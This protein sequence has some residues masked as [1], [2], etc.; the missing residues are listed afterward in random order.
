VIDVYL[1][2]GLDGTGSLFSPF[3][4]AAPVWANTIVV[5]Y[6]N[7]AL[8]DYEQL[9][10]DVSRIIDAQR[11]YILL[12]ESFSGPVAILAARKGNEN[13][14]GLVLSASFAKDPH[15][16]LSKL[17]PIRLIWKMKK[18]LPMRFG[19]R[20]FLAGSEATSK[21][22]NAAE[23]IIRSIPDETIVSR[24]DFVQKIDVSKTLGKLKT[25]VLYMLAT[26]DRSVPSSSLE[27]IKTIFPRVEVAEI[28][29]SHFLLQNRPQE[30]W[31]AITRFIENGSP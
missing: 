3:V 16:F 4:K 8:R 23:F 7:D 1:L 27:T 15:P 6:D 22:I 28:D 19:I 12:G 17:I 24:L 26:K 31:D 25:P 29:T 30:A 10:L 9:A 14:R 20:Y 11:E 18:Y 13:I 2:P 21:F 5:P